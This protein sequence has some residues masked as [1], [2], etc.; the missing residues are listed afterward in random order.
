M[1]HTTK[2]ENAMGVFGLCNRCGKWAVETLRTHSFCWECNY[3]PENDVSLGPWSALEYRNS[4]T[5]SRR[6]VEE[7][8]QYTG[9]GRDFNKNEV[10]GAR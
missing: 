4:K 6:R 5:A 1:F 10:D 3:S 2:G 7:E 8:L 9:E